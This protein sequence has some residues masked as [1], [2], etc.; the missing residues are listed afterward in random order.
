MQ[1]NMMLGELRVLHL[2]LKAEEG[3]WNFTLGLAWAYIWKVKAHPHSETLCSTR[4]LLLIVPHPIGQPFKYTDLWG[5]NL[6]KPTHH[7]FIFFAHFRDWLE[8]FKA[9][10]DSL[11]SHY[12]EGD[13]E[14]VFKGVLLLEETSA[15]PLPPLCFLD[16]GP[17]VLIAYSKSWR[18]YTASLLHCSHLSQEQR[19]H[20]NNAKGLELN[21]EFR[22][23]FEF[24]SAIVCSLV[25]FIK[26]PS[27]IFS[28]RIILTGLLQIMKPTVIYCSPG[29]KCLS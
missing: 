24:V 2:G 23:R 13:K 11:V 3:D 9:N 22:L 15:F 18:Q 1:A 10:Q 8:N 25:P 16:S 12:W 7:I 28:I 27:I 17:L 21:E 26:I 6:F 4:P 14:M 19:Y 5:P 20:G 29:I